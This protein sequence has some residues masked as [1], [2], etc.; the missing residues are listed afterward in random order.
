MPTPDDPLLK[1]VLEFFQTSTL[2][3]LLVGGGVRDFL[4]NKA[5]KDLDFLI[6]GKSID[7]FST[8]TGKLAASLDLNTVRPAAFPEV[9]RLVS[10]AHSLDFTFCSPDNITEN[11][12]ERDF[13]VNAMAMNPASGE[14]LDPAGGLSDLKQKKLRLVQNDAFQKDPVRIIRLFRF[15]TELEFTPDKNTLTLA[16]AAAPL[17]LQPAG[18]RIREELFQILKNDNGHTAI[19]EMAD[20]VLTALFP[21]LAAIRDIPQNGYH[22]LNAFHHT[23][24]VVSQTFHIETLTEKLKATGLELS[25]EDKIVLRLA[26]LFH[27]VGKSETLA[28]KENGIT[29]FKK[30]QF[31]SAALFLKDIARLKPSNLMTERVHMLIRRHMLFL[32]FMLNGWSEKSF[33]KLI[34]MM[35]EDSRLLALLALADKLSAKGPLSA[36][37]IEKM[38]KI[39]QAFMETYKKDAKTITKLPKLVSGDEIMEILGLTPSPEVGKVL[40]TIAEKQLANPAFTR[41][42][43]LKLIQKHRKRQNRNTQ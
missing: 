1:R 2:V 3:P 5:P 34:N 8:V 9:I 4:L 12:M 43:A 20:P 16:N 37:S 26:A 33:R 18:E 7:E 25:P 10:H 27:D 17:L 35:R 30:H 24:A 13:T 14:I 42:Q 19:S 32:N 11:L 22:H 39:G 15:R 21:A 36:G 6:A 40:G 38:T 29:T 31:H 28:W 23:L 41:E